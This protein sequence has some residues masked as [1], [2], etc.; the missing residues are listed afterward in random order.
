MKRGTL[1]CPVNDCEGLSRSF[2]S[3][4]LAPDRAWTIEWFTGFTAD[5]AGPSGAGPVSAEMIHRAF[6]TG[7]RWLTQTAPQHLRASP[8][9]RR[10]S[11]Y[12]VGTHIQIHPGL[13]G[14]Q[15][16][17]LRV[18]ATGNRQ[19]A[20]S[21]SLG[22]AHKPERRVGANEKTASGR[23]QQH[24]PNCGVRL[25]ARPSVAEAVDCILESIRRRHRCPRDNRAAL[26][27]YSGPP[28][29]LPCHGR[30]TGRPR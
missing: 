25:D 20:R 21:A 10:G 29:G 15:G 9:W 14:L 8:G 1:A 19:I 17:P 2:S 11:R 23:P 16:S 4:S 18:D 24:S 12:R 6:T 7:S 13:S 30:A 27:S 22:G 5:I 28:S 26:G 3:S